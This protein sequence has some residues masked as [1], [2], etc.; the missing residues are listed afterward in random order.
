MVLSVSGCTRQTVDVIS[1][2]NPPILTVD[3]DDG[4]YVDQ[5]Q[6]ILKGSSRS[7]DPD[8]P[9]TV[10]INGRIINLTSEGKWNHTVRLREGPNIFVIISR[11]DAGTSTAKK[12]SINRDST[13]ASVGVSNFRNG[14]ITSETS[15]ELVCWVDEYAEV[16]VNGNPV[17][18]SVF[19]EFTV[20][21]TLQEGKNTFTI[22][23]IDRMDRET[24]YEFE[25]FLVRSVKIELWIDRNS[26]IVNGVTK[27]LPQAPILTSPPLPPEL[28]GNTYM[29]IR[30]V[31]ESLYAKVGW[32]GN[33]RK[34][35]LSQNINGKIRNIEL[36]IGKQ[37][38][39]VNGKE[40]WIDD[41]HKLYP[42]IV[43]NKTMLPLRFV[44][45]NLGADVE[46]IGQE[47]KIILKYQP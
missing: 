24:I 31:A 13:P 3:A 43:S 1:H 32:D 28:A 15:V 44:S 33:E 36:W 14:Q 30:E 2:L 22:K 34:V 7:S 35:T 37:K 9:V 26:M 38:A 23:A 5:E 21:K 27:T 6:Y 39:R 16:T 29:P 17:E 45:E 12:I 42:T 46:W 10:T 8:Y 18:L 47:K 11:D 4:I 19:N 41:S 40:V 20:S 25:L